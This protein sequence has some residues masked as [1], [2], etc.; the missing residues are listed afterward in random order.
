LHVNFVV[1]QYQQ[2]IKIQSYSDF[3]PDLGGAA[4]QNYV[5]V[6]A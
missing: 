4:G 6:L 1:N 2:V 5:S 3:S